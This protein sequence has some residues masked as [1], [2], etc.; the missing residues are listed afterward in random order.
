MIS[1]LALLILLASYWLIF[2]NLRA[3]LRDTYDVA[4]TAAVKFA[5]PDRALSNLALSAL[6]CL[7]FW[8][9]FM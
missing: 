4:V 1:V 8:L 7:I 3:V 9:T 2:S 5:S 6:W